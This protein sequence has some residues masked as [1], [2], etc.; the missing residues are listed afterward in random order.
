[1]KK[2]HSMLFIPGIIMLGLFYEHHLLRFRRS[3]LTSLLVWGRCE[4]SGTID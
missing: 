4:L 1:M 3:C 2:T